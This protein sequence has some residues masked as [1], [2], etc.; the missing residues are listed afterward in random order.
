MIYRLITY[1]YVGDYEPCNPANLLKH[2]RISRQPPTVISSTAP[3]KNSTTTDHCACFVRTFPTTSTDLVAL[4]RT[5]VAEPLSIHADMYALGDKYQ[6]KGLCTLAASKFSA[7]LHHHWD[8]KDFITAVQ[9]VY[10]STPD[11]NRGLRDVVVKAFQKYF[12]TDVTKDPSI[13]AKLHKIDGLSFELLKSWPK[14]VNPLETPNTLPSSP[15][16]S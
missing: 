3:H 8:S 2:R 11:S 10:S 6:V 14:K 15:F 1:L 7:C 16:V 5:Q 4:Y 9:A 13:E 12:D